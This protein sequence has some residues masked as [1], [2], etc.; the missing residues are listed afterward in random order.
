[1][2]KQGNEMKGKKNPKQESNKTESIPPVWKLGRS[3]SSLS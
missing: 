1:V 3:Y 2:G